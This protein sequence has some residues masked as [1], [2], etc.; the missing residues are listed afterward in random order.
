[1]FEQYA[2]EFCFLGVELSSAECL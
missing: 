2:A 1:V